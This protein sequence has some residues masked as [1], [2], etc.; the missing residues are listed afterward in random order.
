MTKFSFQGFESYFSTLFRPRQDSKS[1]IPEMDDH[2]TKDQPQLVTVKRINSMYKQNPSNN[3]TTSLQ[4]D[5]LISSSP[6]HMDKHGSQSSL[7]T[8]ISNI[9]KVNSF[10]IFLFMN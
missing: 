8:S 10:F 9:F 1:V 5:Q 7:Q 4:D 2:N 3:S 6:S